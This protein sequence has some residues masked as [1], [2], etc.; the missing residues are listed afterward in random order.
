VNVTVSTIVSQYPDI[1]GLKVRDSTAINVVGQALGA[2]LIVAT[3]DA[4]AMGEK[5]GD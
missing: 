3:G 5:N 2:G 1:D 4:E